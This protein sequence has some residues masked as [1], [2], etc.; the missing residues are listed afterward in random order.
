MTIE[1]E[2]GLRAD[3]RAAASRFVAAQLGVSYSEVPPGKSGCPFHNDRGDDELFVIIEG[4]GTYRYG[5]D[6]HPI[7]AGDV[8]GASAGG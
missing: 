7:R 5:D 8:L 3:I 6:K 4:Q 2:S 1:I